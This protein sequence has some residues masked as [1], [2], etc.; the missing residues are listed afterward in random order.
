MPHTSLGFPH[1][2]L[3]STNWIILYC[4]ITHCSLRHSSHTLNPKCKDKNHHTVCWRTSGLSSPN[5]LVWNNKSSSS[6][7]SWAA[8]GRFPLTFLTTKS[9]LRAER[10]P[11]FGELLVFHNICAVVVFIQ[12]T[13]NASLGRG[14][15]TWL[16]DSAIF[17]TDIHEK[18]A[19]KYV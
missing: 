2:D 13:L 12:V 18:P 19:Q 15:R 1:K 4:Y 16:I 9:R 17:F 10:T 11:R 3:L 5:W 14:K 6:V 7:S 8:C